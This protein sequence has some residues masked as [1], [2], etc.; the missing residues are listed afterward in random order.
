MTDKEFKQAIGR[1][2]LPEYEKMIPAH[3]EHI[4]SQGFESEMDR[5][6]GDRKS[7]RI[8]RS[9]STRQSAA[10]RTGRLRGA[11]IAAVLA[12]AVGTAGAVYLL[13]GRNA[14]TDIKPQSRPD[15]AVQSSSSSS[16][17]SSEKQT[18]ADRLADVRLL[19]DEMV[20]HPE[21]FY[22]RS[23]ARHNEYDTKEDTVKGESVSYSYELAE[24][25]S[26]SGT[27]ES[28]RVLGEYLQKAEI[29][30]L[31]SQYQSQNLLEEKKKTVSDTAVEA[32]TF[33]SDGVVYIGYCS[34]Y[35]T[36]DK[37]YSE[38][39]LAVRGGVGYIK[40][41]TSGLSW[42]TPEE[43]YFNFTGGELP[44]AKNGTAE[45]ERWDTTGAELNVIYAD[46]Q[47]FALADGGEKITVEAGDKSA[48]FTFSI[49]NRG[50]MPVVEVSS[51]ALPQGE[52][53]KGALLEIHLCKY[54]DGGSSIKTAAVM[55]ASAQTGRYDLA[56][57]AGNIS[58]GD[59]DG[60]RLVLNLSTD[61]HPAP[62]DS[63]AAYTLSAYCG[64]SGK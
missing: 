30:Y 21:R 23:F 12:L 13:I 60:I 61:K 38:I 57:Y 31:G 48:G 8:R 53:V 40:I 62:N 51:V 6:L 28:A 19:A 58:K 50:E 7:A 35:A 25:L 18:E 34:R 43:C 52:V 49:D 56:Q 64:V 11:V 39:S 55:T 59:I 29:N 26:E 10:V 32:F 9:E 5:L 14:D 33:R 22:A 20:Q 4:F 47:K 2:L 37:D 42:R 44:L 24:N 16:E 45:L 63:S 17:L 3:E 54:S 15:F 1:V 27:C 46:R 36:R 41:V